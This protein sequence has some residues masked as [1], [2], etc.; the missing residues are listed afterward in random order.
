MLSQSR[1]IHSRRHLRRG[2]IT[3]I[4][5]AE[6]GGNKGSATVCDQEVKKGTGRA[7]SLVEQGKL[8]GRSDKC[9]I[10]RDERR[11]EIEQGEVRSFISGR[12]RVLYWGTKLEEVKLTKTGNLPVLILRK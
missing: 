3:P 6:G 4:P 2:Q 9:N 8:Q 7:D 12:Q 5:R 11:W 10:E 1:A